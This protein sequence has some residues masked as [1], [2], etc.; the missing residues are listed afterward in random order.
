MLGIPRLELPEDGPEPHAGLG[1]ETTRHEPHPGPMTELEYHSRKHPS[2]GA[3]SG[4]GTTTRGDQRVKARGAASIATQT[5]G[6]MTNL[7]PKPWLQSH[8][9][10]ISPRSWPREM[11][12]DVG[13]HRLKGKPPMG[14]VCMIRAGATGQNTLERPE[15]TG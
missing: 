8:S 14:G 4:R 11:R 10:E 7:T 3:R 13:S 12:L 9:E 5:E 15:S 6:A 1:S 2:K